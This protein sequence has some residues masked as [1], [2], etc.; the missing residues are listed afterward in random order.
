M[1]ISYRWFFIY[2]LLFIFYFYY[3]LMLYQFLTGFFVFWVWE[4]G[5]KIGE[6]REEKKRK[7]IVPLRFIPRGLSFKVRLLLSSPFLPI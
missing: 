3:L 6:E 1:L 5:E 7:L 4:R 2:F